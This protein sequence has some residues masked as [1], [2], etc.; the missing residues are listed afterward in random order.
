MAKQIDHV[1]A[2]K[3]DFPWWLDHQ[4]GHCRGRR[5]QWQYL[6]SR[7]SEHSWWRCPFRFFFGSFS[8]GNCPEKKVDSDW[9]QHRLKH[10]F[11]WT[12]M[13]I[14]EHQWTMASEDGLDSWVGPGMSPV[15]LLKLVVRAS[16]AQAL[17]SRSLG[18]RSQNLMIEIWSMGINGRSPGSNRW[19][20]VSTIWLA[21]FWGYIPL[22]LTWYDWSWEISVVLISIDDSWR[23]CD[24][25]LSLL[26]D[27]SLQHGEV[28]IIKLLTNRPLVPHRSPP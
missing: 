8:H 9:N 27:A 12:S 7:V 19:R 5:Q 24:I 14:N 23:V 22:G 11:Q 4:P 6:C 3:L 17:S 21:I 16:R 1:M 18:S 20:Y 26:R 2:T 10:R 13:N 15:A 25:V 28:R